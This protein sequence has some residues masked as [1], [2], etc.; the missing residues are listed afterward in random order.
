M[1]ARVIT[2]LAILAVTVIATVASA[3][4]AQMNVVADHSVHTGEMIYAPASNQPF[5]DGERHCETADAGICA[6]VCVGLPALLTSQG[7]QAGREYASAGHSRPSRVV[8]A[9]RAHGMDER[10][11]KLRL[12]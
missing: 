11:P 2:M 12:L 9:G 7:E 1:F 8:H 10:P 4:A 6:F 3:H 5:C